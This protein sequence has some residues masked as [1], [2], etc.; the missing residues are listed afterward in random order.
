MYGAESAMRKWY[1]PLTVLGL[2]SLGVLFLTERGRTVVRWFFD[3]AERAPDTFLGW[4]EAAQQELDRI[5][6]ALN[7]VAEQLQA[8]Q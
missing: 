3:N 1:V 5:Q 6:A 7:R 8:A 4:N 2:G